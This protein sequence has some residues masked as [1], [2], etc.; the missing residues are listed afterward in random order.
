[1]PQEFI[2]QN[3][4]ITH[5]ELVNQSNMQKARSLISNMQAQASIKSTIETK[6][7]HLQHNGRWYLASELNR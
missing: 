6:Q 2:D 5:Q 4:Q 7:P 1:M 3:E